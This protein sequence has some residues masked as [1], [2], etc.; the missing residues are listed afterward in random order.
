MKNERKIELEMFTMEI[1]EK[2]SI[3]ENPPKH[4]REIAEG[5]HIAVLP[6][7]GWEPEMCGKIMYING[8]PVIF[9]NANHTERM[10]NFTIAHELGHFYLKHLEDQKTEIICMERDLQKIDD[11]K[12]KQEVE[13]NFFAACLLMPFSLLQ[14]AFEAFMKWNDR[15]NG[16][17]YVDKQSC[18][19]RDYKCCIQRMQLYFDVSQTAI[20]YRLINLGWMEFNIKFES[21]QDNG[22]SLAN[23]LEHHKKSN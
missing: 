21:N 8:D 13:A 14:P 17:L 1:L 2:Y 22:I 18:N 5:E 23:Y 19:L 16:V 10:I 6:H 9:Y 11:L 3:S 4:L 12:D 15:S 20:R 7:E